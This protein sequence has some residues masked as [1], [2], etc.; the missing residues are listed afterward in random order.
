MANSNVPMFIQTIENWALQLTP[1]NQA[2]TVTCPEASPAVFTAVGVTAANGLPFYLEGTT[3]PGGFTK[4]VVYYMVSASTD[5]FEGAAQAGGS[6]INNTTSAGTAITL[7]YPLALVAGGAQGSKIERINVCSS[8]TTAHQLTFVLLDA[9]GVGH[10]LSTVLIAAS[11]GFIDTDVPINVLTAANFPSAVYDSNGNPYLY[12]A[13]GW[14]LAVMIGPADG[15][16]ITAAK[17]IDIIAM[18]GNF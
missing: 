9:S 15:V 16:A 8:D 17:T 2:V 13:S 12:V 10:F 4:A 7:F 18:G 14:T 5:T 3:A 6:A 1:L 11:S